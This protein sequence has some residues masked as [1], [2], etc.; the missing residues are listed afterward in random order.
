MTKKTTKIDRSNDHYQKGFAD[1]LA[2][3]WDEIDIVRASLTAFIA[4]AAEEVGRV[5]KGESESDDYEFITECYVQ[6][7]SW[8]VDWLKEHKIERIKHEHSN[9]EARKYAAT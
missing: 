9:N 7:R 4:D 2:L 1:G 3:C 5:E 6:F 8:A